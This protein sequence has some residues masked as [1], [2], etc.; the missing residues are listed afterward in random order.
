MTAALAAASMGYLGSPREVPRQ[1]A[2]ASGEASELRRVAQR[3]YDETGACPTLEALTSNRMKI[4][5]AQLDP[6]G[7]A[8][9]FACREGVVTVVSDGA[10]RKP[11]TSDD[12]GDPVAWAPPQKRGSS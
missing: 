9:W 5:F 3:H 4:G 12:V 10:D 7:K 1:T 11:F 8:Y 2:Q 6:W